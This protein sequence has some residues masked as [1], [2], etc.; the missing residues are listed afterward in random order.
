MNY[1]QKQEHTDAII[2]GLKRAPVE[3]EVSDSGEH[4]TKRSIN[5]FCV[6]C[7]APW[8][9]SDTVCWR[10]ARPLPPKQRVPWTASEILVHG[11]FDIDGCIVEAIAANTASVHCG[12]LGHWQMGTFLNDARAVVRETMPSG[13]VVDTG[14][15]LEL[16]KE[17]DSE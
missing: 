1:E 8:G 15:R 13:Q 11:I 2:D 12:G 5:R 17:V 10:F 4:W 3:C 7:Y 14:R 16:W 6:N 9:Y